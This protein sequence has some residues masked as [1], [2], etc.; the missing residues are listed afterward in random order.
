MADNIG[1]RPMRPQVTG[2]RSVDTLVPLRPA[3]PSLV[4]ETGQNKPLMKLTK[5]TSTV[6]IDDLS[7]G[8]HLVGW[9]SS[10]VLSFVSFLPNMKVLLKDSL[11]GPWGV[12]PGRF[13]YKLTLIR[14]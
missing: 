3:Y 11:V 10:M 8:L 13:E 6:D 7:I 1:T 14:F 2:R 12:L 9:Q 5:G 4:T